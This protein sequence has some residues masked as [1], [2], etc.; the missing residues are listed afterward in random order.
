MC[1]EVDKLEEL[2]EQLDVPEFSEL[3]LSRRNKKTIY[4][5][6]HGLMESESLKSTEDISLAET[7]IQ[8]GTELEFH[9]HKNSYEIIILLSGRLELNYWDGKSSKLNKHDYAIIEKN[10]PHSAIARE[11]SV[12]IALTVPNDSGFPT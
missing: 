5:T 11:D 6:K 9:T 7:F 4:K 3:I 2:Y 10:N 12:F 1:V 8:K